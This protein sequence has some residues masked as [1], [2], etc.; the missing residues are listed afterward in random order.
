MNTVFELKHYVN[1]IVP[2]TLKDYRPTLMVCNP[3]LSTTTPSMPQQPVQCDS[4]KKRLCQSNE[5]KVTSCNSSHT[6][7]LQSC[8]R[9]HSLLIYN[10]QFQSCIYNSV[11]YFLAM[12]SQL[13]VAPCWFR[14]CTE[15]V[16]LWS[17]VGNKVSCM[18]Q[19]N[20]CSFECDWNIKRNLSQDQK[21]IYKAR[22]LPM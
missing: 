8:S 17:F 16:G 5:A 21:K 1:T 14:A 15:Y 3:W 18:Q 22:L 6:A 20:K 12:V 2:I 9:G 7:L 11:G 13:H 4:S 10:T 19:K